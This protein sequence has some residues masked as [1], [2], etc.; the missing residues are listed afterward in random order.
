MNVIVASEV[1]YALTFHGY[2]KLHD[3]LRFREY[4]KKRKLKKQSE[5]YDND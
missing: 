1:H 5:S 3:S 4:G 2:T